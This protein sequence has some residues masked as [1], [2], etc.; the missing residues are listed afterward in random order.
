V[1][2]TAEGQLQGRVGFVQHGE[3]VFRLLGYAPQYRWPAYEGTI[4]GALTSFDKLEDPRRLGVQ[5]ARLKLVRAER[6][7]SLAELARSQSASATVEQLAL[8]NRLGP[9]EP[10]VAGRSYKIVR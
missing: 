1:A 4:R 10:V 5:P 3:H 9:T 8:I 7:M 2:T 6:S